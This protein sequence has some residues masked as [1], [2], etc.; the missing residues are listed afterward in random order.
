MAEHT[1]HSSLGLHPDNGGNL[2]GEQAVRVEVLVTGNCRSLAD[3]R[4]E[5]WGSWRCRVCN[6]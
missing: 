1:G 4:L 2:F 3:V 6:G 5:N